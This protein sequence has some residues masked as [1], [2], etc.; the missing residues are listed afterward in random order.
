MHDK[1]TPK[2]EIGGT[3]A[4]PTVRKATTHVSDTVRETSSGS[5]STAPQAPEHAPVT[6]GPRAQLDQKD[7]LRETRGTNPVVLGA[8]ALA[9]VAVGLA[10]YFTVLA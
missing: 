10:L 6:G 7:R 4:A 2:T 9:V 5:T 8:L 1:T 3:S